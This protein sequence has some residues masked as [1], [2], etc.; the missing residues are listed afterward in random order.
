MSEAHDKWL[1]E[2][3]FLIVGQMTRHAAYKNRRATDPF[4][5]MF[6]DDHEFEKPEEWGLPVPNEE[7]AYKSLAKYAKDCPFM[8]EDQV[9]DL[10]RAWE[11][12]AAHFGPY[13]GNATVRSQEEVVS[14]LDRTTSAGAPFNVLYSTK[15]ELLDYDPEI[16]Q[17]FEESWRLL[18]A[19][20]MHTYLCTNSLK[21]EIRP[22][23]KTAQNKIRTF[24]A[25]AVDA[26][27]DGNRLFADMN[28]RMN[29]AWLTSSSTV[30][31]S[32]MKGNWGRLLEKLQQHPNGYALD[33]SEYDSSLRAYLMW[34]CA[35]FRWTCLRDEDRTPENLRRIKTYYRNLVNTVIISP[36]GTLVMKLGGNPSGSV[37][38]INDNTL[39]LFTLLSYAW[40]RLVPDSRHT[41]LAEFL[42]NVA[43]A[44]CGDDNTW[45]VS[46]EAHPFFNGRNVCETFSL[47]GIITTSDTY[48]PRAAEDLD[49]LSAHTVYLRGFAVPQYNRRKI[50][51]SLLYSNRQ[52]HTP[53][54]ALTR[55]CGM[56]VCGY[57]D[58]VLRKFLRAVIAWLLL[59]FDRVCCDEPEWIV[60]KTGILS[61]QRLFELWTGTSFFL[62]EQCVQSCTEDTGTKRTMS[63]PANKAKKSQPLRGEGA[64]ATRTTFSAEEQ[65]KYRKH[66][67]KGVPK[68]EAKNRILQSRADK[69][70]ASI[71]PGPQFQQK[72]QSA[73]RVDATKKKFFEQHARPQMVA[74]P[75]MKIRGESPEIIVKEKKKKDRYGGRTPEWWEKLMDTGSDLA[76]HFAPMLMGMGDYDEDILQVGPEPAANSILAG[77]SGGK[78]GAGLVKELLSGRS[79]VPTIH[80]DG[81][82]TRIAHREYIGDVLSSTAA[83]TPLEFP[84]NP[85]MKETF[86]WLNQVAANYT[87]Y[88]FLGLVFEFVSEGSEYTNSA[89]L[90]YVGASTQYDAAAAPFVD[91]RSFLNAQFADAAKPSKSFQQWVECSPDRVVDPRRN[92][93]CAANPSNTSINDYDVGKTTLA[94]GGNVAAGAVIGEWWV[95]YDVLLYVPRSQ[96]FVNTTID[97]F[98]VDSAAA[99]STDAAPLGSGWFATAN[100]SNTFAP[101]LTG[102]SITFPNGT[103]GRVVVLLSLVRTN[104]ATAG[105]GSYTTTLVGCSV[106]ANSGVTIAPSFVATETGTVQCN[107]YDIFSDGASITF[108]NSLSFFGAGTGTMRLLI[109]Q[110]PAGLSAVSSI[111]DYGGLN[112]EANYT[113]LMNLITK[114]EKAQKKVLVETEIFRVVMD[115]EN[116]RVWFYVIADSDTMY[117]LPIE[118]LVSVLGK[119]TE[120][121]DKYLM[122]RLCHERGTEI[123]TIRR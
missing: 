74:S 22:T 64:K 123:T 19:D 34:G 96:G 8:E 58:V 1:P 47:I 86:P 44:L 90:G 29:S 120:F 101:T 31:W 114:K 37:N 63:S 36:E 81:M 42:N 27:V 117:F 32:P 12:T 10:N 60:A 56:L 95:S 102:N 75:R 57:T 51:T 91:K 109:T 24:T 78:K 71:A 94:V 59:K 113:K 6:Y 38:T 4:I 69:Q 5:E 52:K 20:P 46:D 26:T 43:L 82:V 3:Y 54:N 112:R 9:R 92:V 104:T 40:I 53:A 28:E 116:S 99:S 77:A 45:T 11:W 118:E 16:L 79:D 66:L 97:K 73:L 76:K 25:M 50:L 33:E 72:P 68:M 106:V 89:G 55:T 111:F 85:G 122:E 14:K 18:E 103:R 61:D 100:A 17:V 121:V 70:L 88:Q 23:E 115:T 15:G 21:E 67:S 13:M 62:T 83:F 93:R 84:L 41:S 7:A 2:S 107:A 108:A 39:I 110:I 65:E 80:E 98:S 87:Q 105:S 35:R 30:G 48:E 119:S 49:Y